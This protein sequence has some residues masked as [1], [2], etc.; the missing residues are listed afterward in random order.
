MAT[1]AFWKGRIRGIV[2]ALRREFPAVDIM[3]H[4]LD[5]RHIFAGE[6]DPGFLKAMG[7]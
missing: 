7:G 2:D 3:M 4:G 6:T 1:A 5:A